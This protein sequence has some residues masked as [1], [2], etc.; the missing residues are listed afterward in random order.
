MMRLIY[1]QVQ[2]LDLPLSRI[3]NASRCLKN[4]IHLSTV[5]VYSQ[6]YLNLFF[7]LFLQLNFGKRKGKR[8][9]RHVSICERL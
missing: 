1:I 4:I 7:H 8:A 5:A 2:Q 9:H 3:E 6:N